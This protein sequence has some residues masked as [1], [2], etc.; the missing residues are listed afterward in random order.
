MVFLAVFFSFYLPT[1][2]E[3]LLYTTVLDMQAPHSRGPL[4]NLILL[5]LYKVMNGILLFSYFY[6]TGYFFF[7]FPKLV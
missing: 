1:T 2:I 4:C 6:V 7:L 3:A 5:K